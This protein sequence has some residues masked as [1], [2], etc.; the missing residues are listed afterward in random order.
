[1]VGGK[2]RDSLRRDE[3]FDN[4]RWLA[5]TSSSAVKAGKHTL[6]IVMIDPEIVLEQVVINPDNRQIQLFRA[7]LLGKDVKTVCFF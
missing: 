2:G 6:R 5:A 7:K 3:V 4:Q 1:M